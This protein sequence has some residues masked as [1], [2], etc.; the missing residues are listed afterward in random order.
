VRPPY[1]APKRRLD[2]PDFI[3]HGLKHIAISKAAELGVPPH[4]QSRLFDHAE[5]AAAEDEPQLWGVFESFQEAKS[6]LLREGPVRQF[7]PD[8][9]SIP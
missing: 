8:Q 1:P 6:S 5:G 4:I 7:R 3:W 2:Q 9:G